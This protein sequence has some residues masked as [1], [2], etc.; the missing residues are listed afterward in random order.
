M[1]HE[2]GISTQELRYMNLSDGFERIYKYIEFHDSKK[3]K[4]VRIATQE[5]IDRF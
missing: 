3:K 4:P 5:D 1:F 2:V